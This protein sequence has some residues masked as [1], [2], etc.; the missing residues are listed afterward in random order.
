MNCFQEGNALTDNFQDPLN[1]C[2]DNCID[3]CE[4]TKYIIPINS[5]YSYKYWSEGIAT[6]ELSIASF[7]YPV[8]EETPKWTLPSFIGILGGALGLWLGINI[9]DTI[10]Y[11]MNGIDMLIRAWKK[12]DANKTIIKAN[13]NRVEDNHFS[14]DY[15]ERTLLSYGKRYIQ[16]F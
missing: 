4:R 15:N 5:Y 1:H 13:S 3:I 14:S 7:E 12:K 9:L 10:G 2:K 8:F 16:V 6:V 11:A